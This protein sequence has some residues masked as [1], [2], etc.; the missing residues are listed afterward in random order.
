[1]P[2]LR[3]RPEDIPHL[4]REMARELGGKYGRPAPRLSDAAMGVLVRHSWPGNIR[5]LRNAV[6][7]MFLLGSA[8]A[9]S[10]AWL[11]EMLAAD[12]ALGDRLVPAASP[13]LSLTAKRDRLDEVLQRHDGNKTAAAR[14]LG[15]TRKT[16][17]K[18]LRD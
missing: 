5:E 16:I 6:E 14:E 10:R 8:A 2:P 13:H 7:R 11:E 9:P 4:V 1:M 12:R 3:D 18:W 17:H 15:V